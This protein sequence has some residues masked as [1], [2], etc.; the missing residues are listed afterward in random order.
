MDIISAL[1]AI[2]VAGPGRHC[3]ARSNSLYF[4]QSSHWRLLNITCGKLL[5]AS[6]PVLLTQ[7]QLIKF[8]QRLADMEKKFYIAAGCALVLGIGGA[9]LTKQLADASSHVAGLEVKLTTASEKFTAAEK[10]Y[11]DALT[12][13]RDT[14][15]E[16]ID[17]SAKKAVERHVLT[18]VQPELGKLGQTVNAKFTEHAKW[19]NFIYDHAAVNHDTSKGANGWWQRAI[20]D[21]KALV[22]RELK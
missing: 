20:I 15:I 3:R 17:S 22:N 14:M 2:T 1:R 19:I 6:D 12:K 13:K 16:E 5:V 7:D 10:G 8:E 9:L 11:S 21:Q 18:A 4:N